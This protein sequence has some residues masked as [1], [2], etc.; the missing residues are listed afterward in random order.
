MWEEWMRTDGEF[1]AA[2]NRRRAS[3]KQVAEWVLKAWEDI[4]TD[5]IKKSFS[6]CGIRPAESQEPLKLHKRLEALLEVTFDFNH[7]IYINRLEAVCVS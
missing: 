3:Y 6:L 7:S 5:L 4:P 1:T 2:G